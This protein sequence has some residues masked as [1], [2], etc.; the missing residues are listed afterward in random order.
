M[1]ELTPPHG[2]ATARIIQERAKEGK[3][4]YVNAANNDAVPELEKQLGKLNKKSLESSFLAVH[5]E[6]FVIFVWL[7]LF[8]I[9]ADIF[10]LDRKI[11]WL[12]K[13]TFFKSTSRKKESKK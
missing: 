13:F 9:I 12:D 7:A 1:V 10:L 5:D 11:G 6:L 8:F 4:I 3:G 2:R